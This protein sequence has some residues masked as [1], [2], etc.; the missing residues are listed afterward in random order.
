MKYRED[1]EEWWK[2]NGVTFQDSMKALEMSY[3]EIALNA[4]ESGYERG[5]QDARD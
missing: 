2:E 5:L 4:Y 3:K 1:F